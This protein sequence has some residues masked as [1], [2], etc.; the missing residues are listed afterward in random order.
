MR[1]RGAGARNPSGCLPSFFFFTLSLSLVL[2]LNLLVRTP[3]LF[4]DT[5]LRALAVHERGQLAP[6]DV[7]CIAGA[8]D[9]RRL[10]AATPFPEGRVSG[11]PRGLDEERVV[12][13]AKAW[14]AARSSGQATERLLDEALSPDFQL[15]DAYGMLPVGIALC[16]VGL[17]WVCCCLSECE[18]A[19]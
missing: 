13:S 14:C 6:E 11:Y 9:A 17:G 18:C 16:W 3:V 7:L 15:T 8:D 12:R 4:D 5:A 1:W 19:R 2:L 10:C